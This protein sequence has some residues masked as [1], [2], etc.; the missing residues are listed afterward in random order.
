MPI[1]AIIMIAIAWA[2][3]VFMLSV[4]L[5]TWR[6]RER[7]RAE[8]AEK[9]VKKV[10]TGYITAEKIKAGS[11]TADKIKAGSIYD[12]KMKRQIDDQES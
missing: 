11:I 12:C 7:Q 9:W 4:N 1:E 6:R 8:F 3:A 10:S 2:V 5:I